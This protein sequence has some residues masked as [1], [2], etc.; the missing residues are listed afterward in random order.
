MRISSFLT[1][2]HQIT[3]SKRASR[4]D[5]NHTLQHGNTN[6][7]AQNS[8]VKLSKRSKGIQNLEHEY[9]QQQQ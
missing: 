4:I 2:S 1:I 8:R 7:K 6:N 3:E 5:K 9:K